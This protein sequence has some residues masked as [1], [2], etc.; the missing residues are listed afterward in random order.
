MARY[1]K[2]HKKQ[3][4]AKAGRHTDNMP[5]WCLVRIEGKDARTH[6]AK[7]TGITRHWSRN[8]TDV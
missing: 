5:F 7:Y 8:D 3:K 4:L 1:N 6:P 2:P